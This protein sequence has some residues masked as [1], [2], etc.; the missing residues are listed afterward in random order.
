MRITKI[1]VKNFR[2][3]KDFEIDLEE[4]I[5][6]IIGKNNSGKTSLLVLLDKFLLGKPS[7]TNFAYDDF[8]IDFQSYLKKVIEEQEGIEGS[9]PFL[10]IS[11][12]LF[13]EYDEN[14][15]LSNIGNKIVMDLDPENNTVVLGYEYALTEQGFEGLKN[16]FGEMQSS[17]TEDKGIKPDLNDFLKKKH[18]RYF[19]V[20]RKSIAFD[21]K[22]N[23]E[24]DLV[25]TDLIKEKIPLQ[26]VVN[27]KIISAKRQVSNKETDRSL[28]SLTSDIYAKI[29][30]GDD[31]PQIINELRGILSDTDK[32][33]DSIYAKIF[34]DILNDV[35]RLGG[36]RKGETEIKIASDLR[37]KDLLEGNT[38]VTYT[39]ESNESSLPENYNGLGYMN[40]IGMIFE[41][42]I[43][44]DEFKKSSR[45]KPADI[46]LLFIEEPEAHTHPQMQYA[47]IRNIKK[48]LEES[49]ITDDG[50]SINLQTLI[51][52]H[53]SHIVSEC[54]FDDIKYFKKEV[55][56][57]VSKNLKDLKTEYQ[58]AGQEQYFK[59]LKQYLTL[60]RSELFFAEKAIFI[61]GDTERIL[62]PAMIKQLD[63]DDL[64]DPENKDLMP[65][66]SQNVSIIEV[67]AYSHVFEKFIDFIH[68]TS[69]VITDIDSCKAEDKKSC[70]VSEGDQTGNYSLKFFYENLSSLNDFTEATIEERLLLKNPESKKWEVDAHGHLLCVYQTLE[71]NDEEQSYHARSFEDVFLHT[72]KKFLKAIIQ[73]YL[74]EKEKD[75]SK[76][77][78]FPSL[79]SKQSIDEYI[80]GIDVDPYET[81][82]SAIGKKP[83]FAMEILLNS[84]TKFVDNKEIL[85]SNWKSPAYIREGLQWLKKQ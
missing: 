38:L 44:L 4:N 71:E 50:D 43:K 16:D 81:A 23:I 27:Y 1:K 52:T 3:L 8:N 12:K 21:A 28:S 78:P 69:L 45:L 80:N 84:E 9:F 10:G 60:N 64:N 65:L 75:S 5:S 42:K 63:Q 19:R 15:D 70:K 54:D 73:N 29:Q 20:F 59:F 24:N 68:I 41:I 66:T 85:Y 26:N 6:L 46:N 77:H 79:K 14:D 33:L 22:K 11:L 55:G 51:S 61:E 72:N 18:S 30:G 82:K 83:S 34:E 25:F 32:S 47:F 62:L 40:L 39:S 74:A 58:E 31:E 13:L 35:N 56:S 36:I 67:G 17:E 7:A 49:M 76:Q 57:V 48:L 37:D 2:L 53:S